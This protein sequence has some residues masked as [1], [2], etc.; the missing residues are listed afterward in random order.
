MKT[1]NI[2]SNNILQK[3]IFLDGKLIDV[4]DFGTIT[5][6]NIISK[7]TNVSEMR[8]NRKEPT[9]TILSKYDI[10]YT[11]YNNVCNALQKELKSY[12]S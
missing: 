7:N 1:L 9:E 2:V 11:T 8:F 12:I 4:L 3:E 6:S 5:K 10:D